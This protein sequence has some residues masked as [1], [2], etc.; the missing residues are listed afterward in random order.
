MKLRVEPQPDGY[1]ADKASIMIDEDQNQETVLI[2][3][4]GAHRVATEIAHRVNLYE[5]LLAVLTPF[6]SSEMGAALIDAMFYTD[7]LSDGDPVKQEAQKRMRRLVNAV[8]VV[9]KGAELHK[10]RMDQ[11]AA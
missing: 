5:P 9:L 2:G 11:W 7:G 1:S 10:E 4:P 8:D 6:R 3:C